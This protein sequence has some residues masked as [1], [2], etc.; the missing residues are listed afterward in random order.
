MGWGP[1]QWAKSSNIFSSGLGATVF[2]SLSRGLWSEYFSNASTASGEHLQTPDRF[3]DYV[4][5]GD[6]QNS[7]QAR[8]Q[9][10]RDASN[11]GV[12]GLMIS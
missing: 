3:V 4:V 8:I 5:K 7:H 6:A 9:N 2:T 11:V 10:V 12:K 1:L